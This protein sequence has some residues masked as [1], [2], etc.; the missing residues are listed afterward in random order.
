ML[1]ELSTLLEVVEHEELKLTV[2]C[3]VDGLVNIRLEVG[4]DADP[5]WFFTQKHGLCLDTHCSVLS[6]F[7]NPELVLEILTSSKEPISGLGLPA[8]LLVMVVQEVGLLVQPFNVPLESLPH[9]WLDF[10]GK[11]LL[12]SALYCLLTWDHLVSF[13]T[14]EH[15]K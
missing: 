5:L 12:D 6:D 8:I 7:E 15:P 10:V 9:L 4:V 2:A 1:F 11:G 13:E 14:L 3:A